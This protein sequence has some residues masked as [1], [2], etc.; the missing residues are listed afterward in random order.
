MIS[1]DTWDNILTESDRESLSK[2]L[3][4]E[5]SADQKESTISYVTWC[6][7]TWLIVTSFC[8]GNCL[9]AVLLNSAPI[10][11]QT[12]GINYQ[13]EEEER[14]WK[15]E[16]GRGRKKKRERGEGGRRRGRVMIASEWVVCFRWRLCEGDFRFEGRI[17]TIE[18]STISSNNKLI[19]WLIILQPLPLHPSLSLSS[20]KAWSITTWTYCKIFYWV[21]E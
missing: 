20:S 1:R 6:H 7:V 11:W 10:Q 9:G 2:L 5:L 4:Q 12:H 16:R 17:E 8:K 21:K 15:G 18:I 19:I 13:V 14:G 3:P